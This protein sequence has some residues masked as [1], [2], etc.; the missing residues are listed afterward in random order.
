[1][2]P[3][4]MVA[5]ELTLQPHVDVIKERR[6]KPNPMAPHIVGAESKICPPL[7]TPTEIGPEGWRQSSITPC[8][9]LLILWANQE[10]YHDWWYWKLR[11][12]IAQRW[13][14]YPQPTHTK[15]HPKGQPMMF[16]FHTW[17]WIL[18]KMVQII[19]FLQGFLKLLYDKLLY[20]LPKEGSDI[21]DENYPIKRVPA[22]AS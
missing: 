10:D 13:M 14:H 17:V 22:M 12:Q 15:V 9:P 4:P 1:M 21:L 20:H 2:I 3:H 8:C 11:G 5:D 16:L 7:S 18:I 19:Y 6:K